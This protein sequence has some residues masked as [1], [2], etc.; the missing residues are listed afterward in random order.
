[1][2][3]PEFKELGI[4]M[5]IHTTK[6]FT[7]QLHHCQSYQ[8]LDRNLAC[9]MLRQAHIVARIQRYG[10]RQLFPEH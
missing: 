2:I 9:Y 1:M 7:I 8:Q 10:G 4:Q 3:V 5:R 6:F